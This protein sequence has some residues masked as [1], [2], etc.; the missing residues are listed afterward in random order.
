MVKLFFLL[1]GF[2]ILNCFANEGKEFFA[3]GEKYYEGQGVPKD[4]PR[5]VH[6]YEEAAKKRNSNAFHKLGLL[7]FLGR[8][9]RQDY[10]KASKL[11]KK[12]AEQDASKGS[13]TSLYFLGFSYEKLSQKNGTLKDLKKAAE[14]Y[15]RASQGGNH[16]S[17]CALAKLYENGFGVPQDYTRAASLYRTISRE[18][19]PEIEER[20]NAFLPRESHH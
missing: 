20:L 9:V 7:Y 6:Y 10:K 16:D 8:G 4:I 13:Y 5:A 1:Y 12:I 2:L 19:Y 15:Q 11:F 18:D 14:C 17:S 3:L